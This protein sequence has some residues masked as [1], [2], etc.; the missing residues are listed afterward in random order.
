M[1]C[2]ISELLNS[3]GQWIQIYQGIETIDDPYEKNVT[4]T[5]MEPRAVKAI[6]TDLTT[7][8]VSWKMPG[9]STDRAKSIIVSRK[10]K[11]LI[12][13]SHKIDIVN[14]D[15]LTEE[16]EGWRVNG[17]MQIRELGES[18]QVYIY[19]RKI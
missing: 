13:S 4:V 14:S 1:S 18:L 16:Y 11:S 7:A 5:F 3:E 2:G 6:V 17:R 12:E 15:R 19:S 9:I 8:Q 10:Y